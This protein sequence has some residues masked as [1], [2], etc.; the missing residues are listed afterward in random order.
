MRKFFKNGWFEI[1]GSCVQR[2]IADNFEWRLSKR[3]CRRKK[4]ENENP[5]STFHSTISNVF[6]T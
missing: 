1:S 4:G 2:I 3:E 5:R 6:P